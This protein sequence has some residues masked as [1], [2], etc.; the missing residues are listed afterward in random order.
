MDAPA[1][2]VPHVPCVPLDQKRAEA[3][4]ARLQKA[5]PKE[6]GGRELVVEK[7]AIAG[8]GTFYRVQTGRF[9]TLKDARAMCASL[10]GKKQACLPVT[11]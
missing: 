3:E 4:W 8:R 1:L 2:H 9:E 7:R 5:F 11:R 6:F 10:K